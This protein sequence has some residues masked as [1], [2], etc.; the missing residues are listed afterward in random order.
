MKPSKQLPLSYEF[1][2]KSSNKNTNT[3]TTFQTSCKVK[4]TMRLNGTEVA[5]SQT[6]TR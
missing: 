3:L 2:R 1:I 4:V 6:N 5:M